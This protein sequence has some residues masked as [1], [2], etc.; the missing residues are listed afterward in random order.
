MNQSVLL[1]MYVQISDQNLICSYRPKPLD[2]IR[3]QDCGSPLE[4]EMG[5]LAENQPHFRHLNITNLGS[6][7]VSLDSIETSGTSEVTITF[8]SVHPSVAGSPELPLGILLSS[9]NSRTR[10]Q[11]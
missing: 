6:D 3:L 9:D 2:P 4:F 11:A 5:D 7:M 1:P 8:D 10:I